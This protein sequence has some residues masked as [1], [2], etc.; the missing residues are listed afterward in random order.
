MTV[1][2]PGAS[3]DWSMSGR[4]CLITGATAGI[5]RAAAFDVARLGAS[6]VLVGRDERRL[7]R[8][9]REISAEVPS[10]ELRVLRA[11]FRSLRAVR[12]LAD[13][14]NREVP[15]LDVLVCNAGVFTN[16]R[17]ESADGF[18][19]QLAVNHLAPF[20]LT[21]PLLDKLRERVPS[22]VVVVASQVEREG[23][24]DFEDLHGR[25]S[26]DGMRAYRQSKLANVLFA[27]ELSRRLSGSGVT[28]I[29]L[30]P[31]VY[32]TRLLDNFMGWSTLLTRLRG[33]SGLPPLAR[34]G[35]IIARAVAAPELNGKGFVHLH[36][37]VA[38]DPSLRAQ[39]DDVAR[40]LWQT[41]SEL[42]ALG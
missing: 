17:S 12:Q 21:N 14:V 9:Q 40:R 24:I 28:T 25:R 4:V 20:L 18:E 26:Y 32:S 36:E 23:V 39:D 41:S 34:A 42:V 29:S 38:R 27:R 6:L 19:T 11:D 3:A 22:R 1:G 5:G 8:V 31:G 10:A 30:H 33:R 37:H 13:T 35:E 15:R 7:R 2:V 16:R